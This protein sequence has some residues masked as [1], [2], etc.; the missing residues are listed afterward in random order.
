MKKNAVVVV[1]GVDVVVVVV[2][3]QVYDS[4][5]K[6]MMN[7]L[8]DWLVE[9][10]AS[11]VEVKTN[12]N[13]IYMQMMKLMMVKVMMNTKMKMMIY[14]KMLSLLKPMRLMWVGVSLMKN[15]W[16]KMTN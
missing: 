7:C 5:M 2:V 16:K 10:I 13:L 14:Y 1:A 11:Q 3:V 12:Y 4:K 9:V 15:Y 8:F 6:M